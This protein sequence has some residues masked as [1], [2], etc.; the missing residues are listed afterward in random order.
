MPGAVKQRRDTRFIF[1]RCQK[2][3]ECGV[4][5]LFVD[6]HPLL[7]Y[8]TLLEQTTGDAA[9]RGDLALDVLYRRLGCS[10]MFGL[11]AVVDVVIQQGLSR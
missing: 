3:F 5:Y 7:D 10:A 11:D 1:C 2:F 4:A 6:F 9:A 8:I